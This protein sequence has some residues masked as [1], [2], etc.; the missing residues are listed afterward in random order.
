MTDEV[1]IFLAQNYLN[2]VRGHK[3]FYESPLDLLQHCV[4]IYYQRK[5]QGLEQ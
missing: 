4:N 2:N 1:M 3:P 5:E